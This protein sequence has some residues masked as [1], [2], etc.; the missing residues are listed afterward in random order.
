MERLLVPILS[1]SMLELMDSERV[2]PKLGEVFLA[3]SSPTGR[4]ATQYKTGL[5]GR[6]QV[7]HF[8]MSLL[9]SWMYSAPQEAEEAMFQSSGIATWLRQL[10]LEDHDPAVRREVCTGIYR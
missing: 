10:L 5:F 4:E 1:P 2:M 8:A 3:A 6:G 7:V 9:V